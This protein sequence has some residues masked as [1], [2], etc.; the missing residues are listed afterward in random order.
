MPSSELKRFAAACAEFGD[1]A[2]DETGFVALHRVAALLK[3]EVEFRPML[4]EGVIAKPKGPGA[5]KVLIDSDMH[6]VTPEMFASE[7]RTKPL[8]AR[9]RNTVAHELLHT[10]SFRAEEFGF[11]L[12]RQEKETRADA[13]KRFEA[14][15]ES[16]SPFLL[17]SQAFLERQLTEQ[18][19]SVSTAVAWRD[20]W[21]LS[22]EVVVSRLGLMQYLPEF[23]LRYHNSVSNVAIG[24]A[25]WVTP[26]SA[27]L[28][29]WPLYYSFE[30]GIVPELVLKARN[31]GKPRLQDLVVDLAC[32]LN[33]GTN[34]GSSVEM[35]AGTSNNPS[36]DRLPVAVTLEPVPREKGE[37]FFV[38]VR[39]ERR[40]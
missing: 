25:E 20:H 10:L 37:T 40:R 7:D 34:S 2:A 32:Y 23:R 18:E 21:A 35:A 12:E 28:M 9:L 27:T 26:D 8:T 3:A 29:E 14:E 13:L 5:W 4:V 24:L 36:S 17:M 39:S 16:F 1:R 30:N 33:G 6:E 11:A 22:R 31:K 15:T 38:T 19:L